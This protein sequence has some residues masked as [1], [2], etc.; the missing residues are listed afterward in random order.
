[1][2][3][4]L[5]WAAPIVVAHTPLLNWLIAQGVKDL[6][7]T[8][9]IGHASLGWFSPVILEEAEV[10]DTLGR[11]VLSAARIES[12]KSLL[13]LLTEPSNLGSLRCQGVTIEIVCSGR[14]TNLEGMLAHW[15]TRPADPSQKGSFEGVAL[16]LE[17]VDARL[18]VHDTD[19]NEHWTLDPI[20]LNWTLPPPGSDTM[21]LQVRSVVANAGPPGVIE[22]DLALS[23]STSSA[24]RLQLQLDSL[25]LALAKPVLRRTVPDAQLDGRLSGQ[26]VLQWGATE[27]GAPSLNLDGQVSGKGLVVSGPWL[28]GDHLRLEQL[29]APLHLVMQGS[30]LRVERAEVQCD[31]G[32]AS[33]RGTVDTDRIEPAVLARSPFQ[34]L[35]DL[36]LARLA[37][38]LPNTLHLRPDTRITSGRL[39]VDVS[40]SG[41]PQGSAW[42]GTVQVSALKA[43][44][45][46]QQ[47]VLPEPI[48]IA[49]A[50]HEPPGAAVIVDRCRCES[51]F[52][53]L[54]AAGT[55]DRLTAS[56]DAD[57]SGLTAQFA[58]LVDLGSLHLT[59]QGSARV[60]LERATD[61]RFTLHGEGQVRQLQMAG[62]TNRPVQEAFVN[63]RLEAAGNNLEHG[64][65]RLDS[66]SFRLEG[67]SEVVDV[68]LLEPIADLQHGRSGSV[69]MQ[70]QGDLTSWQRRAQP[71]TTALD[72]WQLAG[73][74][75]LTARL[76]S[77][78]SAVN[79]EELKLALRDVSC[80]GADLF[81][82]EPAIELETTGSW[83]RGT[84]KLE[85]TGTRVASGTVSVQAPRLHVLVPEQG[86]IEIA[87]S[88]TVQGDLARLQR[89]MIPPNV[90][91]TEPLAGKLAGQVDWQHTAGQLL[92]SLDLN[93][94]EV[95]FGP[96]AAPNWREPRI[97]LIGRGRYDSAADQLRIEKLQ[98]DSAALGC[99]A[100]GTIA[101]L[102]GSRDLQLTGQLRY[103]MERLG[104]LV[105]PTLGPGVVV[106][107]QDVRPFRVEGSLAATGTS[108][109]PGVVLGPSVNQPS[110]PLLRTLTAEGSLSWKSAAAYGF[111]A[112]P[113][114]LRARLTGGWLRV[115]PIECTISGGRLRLE[116]ALRVEPGPI[117]LT[118]APG[119][120]IDHVRIT[121]AICAN[122]LKYIAPVLA[123]VAEAEGEFS[124]A[125][126]SARIPIGT[127]ALA[128]VGGQLKV[129]SVRIGA[130]PL[131][132]ELSVLLKDAPS[133]S[134]ARESV[135]TFYV[136]NG[137]VYHRGLELVFPELTIRTSGS[138]GFDGS[139]TLLA[140]MPVPPKWLGSGKVSA[141]IAQQTIRIPISGTLEKP[142]LDQQTLRALNAQF[143]RDTTGDLLRQG[144][145]KKLQKL[146]RPRR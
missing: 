111:Q 45:Q 79:I 82:N 35:A 41:A 112:G 81:V 37:N 10:R 100:Q 2:L 145:D 69:R 101:R 58:S 14:E 83:Q 73:K 78:G 20:N 72:G 1:M 115:N 104:A 63:V 91:I 17:V 127:P 53:N 123:D 19:A 144:A 128:A 139:L 107:G 129:H 98:V 117:E 70:V 26:V 16:E 126:E 40:S 8:V 102:S 21:R 51:S 50:A 64:V 97:H 68:Q 125:L 77:T 55:A 3:L 140:E 80:R 13:S 66:A 65:Q 89:W 11:P 95:T 93:L 60:V 90:P 130:G 94:L 92:G 113:A 138:V 44:R 7:G 39:A 9:T 22:V 61:G 132:R 32:K 87:G 84:H 48:A 122:G 34:A 86:T 31:L 4:F 143:V 5:V 116:P 110:W 15:L 28:E 103:D 106:A 142:K 74:G 108:P 131:V 46:G 114:E 133:T 59:G 119:T 135:V 18:T 38:M 6:H 56:V 99:D 146:I 124:V 23:R 105:R 36:D 29:D 137:Q 24:S 27:V 57:L 47:I 134:L 76:R 136:V 33:V 12:N 118:T 52:L 88:A 120:V 75:G 43:V 54:E 62:F 109:A 25:P 71:W 121:P 30:T 85:L 96:M 67:G 42:Q 141:A 49:F